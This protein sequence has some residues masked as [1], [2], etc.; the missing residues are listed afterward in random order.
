M[1]RKWLWGC[2]WEGGKLTGPPAV[3]LEFWAQD[4][5]NTVGFT[6][7]I[8]Q[9]ADASPPRPPRSGRYAIWWAP[10]GVADGAL[11]F[12][13]DLV[14]RSAQY[15]YYC[16]GFKL[17][18]F[19]A[20]SNLQVNDIYRV[21]RCAQT[22]ALGS[23]YIGHV[24]QITQITPSIL[25]KCIAVNY[26][27]AGAYASGAGS[28]TTTFA[29]GHADWIWFVIRLNT[30]TQATAIFVNDTNEGTG[31]ATA[32]GVWNGEML[33]QS[34]LTSG[35]GTDA[36]AQFIY[37]DFCVAESTLDTDAPPIT[38]GIVM[39][40][41]DADDG[42]T[43]T[44]WEGDSINRYRNWDDENDE[45]PLPFDR[46]APTASGQDQ[47]GTVKDEASGIVE[48]VRIIWAPLLGYPTLNS[49]LAKTSGASYVNL[50]VGVGAY[51]G[52]RHMWRTP[53]AVSWTTAL[54]NSLKAGLRSGVNIEAAD[55]DKF[56]P[57]AIGQSLVRPAK[58]PAPA[59]GQRTMRGVV[60]G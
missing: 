40:Q 45:A 4:C 20:P 21:T 3:S 60:V 47:T 42:N 28:G 15:I 14:A 25:F 6:G 52:G 31:D 41:P 17:S 36:Y 8:F 19:D 43:W 56:Y 13:G 44:V 22:V 37:D 53:E 1:A 33:P 46:N 35:K 38:T 16:V 55:V 2:G 24:I 9:D 59:V 12:V 54:F 48:A 10:A 11:F 5:W 49:C 34:G 23:P 7:D 27:G 58:T 32:G 50:G 30:T 18:H 51:W 57:M 29:P 39:Y 26:D